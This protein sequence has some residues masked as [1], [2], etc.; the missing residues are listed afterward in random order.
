MSSVEIDKEKA[1]FDAL[2]ELAKDYV[3]NVE[4]GRKQPRGYYNKLKAALAIKFD[5]YA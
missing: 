5:E 4:I 3:M 1:C 2:V